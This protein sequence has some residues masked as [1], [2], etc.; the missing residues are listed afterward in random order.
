MVENVDVFPLFWLSSTVSKVVD[1]M[2]PRVA[3]MR[4]RYLSMFSDVQVRDVK[5]GSIASST[6]N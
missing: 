5:P 6:C 1:V 3:L 2:L 4:L